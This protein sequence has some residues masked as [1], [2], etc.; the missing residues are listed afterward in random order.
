MHKVSAQKP[1]HGIEGVGVVD[2]RELA[3]DKPPDH[4]GRPLQY[5]LVLR[6]SLT[7]LDGLDM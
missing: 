2:K 5:T 7:N 1:V 3:S 4:S 6:P